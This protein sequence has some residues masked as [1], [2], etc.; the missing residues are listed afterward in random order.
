MDF[1]DKTEKLI[2]DQGTLIKAVLV[3]VLKTSDTLL[4]DYSTATV[5]LNGIAVAS[6]SLKDLE[7]DG[8]KW[9][10]KLPVEILKTDGSMNQLSIVTAQRS[11]LGECADIDN[12]ANWVLIS[13]ESALL[14]TLVRSDDLVLSDLKCCLDGNCSYSLLICFGCVLLAMDFEGDLFAFLD[15][16]L[17]VYQLG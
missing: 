15:F 1:K 11:I 14:L 10:V 16:A 17:A 4:E 7:K 2:S 13:D 8:N 3:I 6:V 12:P 5:E 9:E